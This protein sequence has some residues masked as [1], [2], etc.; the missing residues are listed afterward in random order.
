MWIGV[1]IAAGLAVLAALAPEGA[2]AATSD[3]ARSDQAAVR[4]V[5]ASDAVGGEKAIR[6]GF[7]VELAPGWKIYWRS[8]G[9]AGLPPEFDWSGS[10]NLGT[11]ETAWPVPHRFTLFG[12]DTF[13]Y[14]TEVVLPLTATVARSGE[15]VF[16]RTHVRYLVCDP[17][18]CVPQEA[19][20]ALALPGGP[21]APSAEA[22]LIQRF[23]VRVP[24]D[25]TDVGLFLEGVRLEEAAG[26]HILVASIRGDPPLTTPDLIV[27]G[28]AAYRF[29]APSVTLSEGGRRGV[30]RVEAVPVEPNPPAL[31]ATTLTLT[32]IDGSRGLERRVVPSATPVAPSASALAGILGL[33]LLGGFI[34]NFMPCVL[35]VLSIK[36]LGVIRQGGQGRSRV[37]ASFL[38]TAAGVVFSFLA[39]AASLALLKSAGAAIGWGIQFQQPLFLTALAL[40]L[41]LFAGNLFGF[42]EVPLPGWAGGLAG[43][44]GAGAEGHGLLGPFAAG[45]FATLLATP[46]S[47]PFLGTAVG[48]ALA[49]GGAE[50]FAIFLA[51][52]LGLAAPYLLVAA[53]PGLVRWLP[54][55]GR[56]MRHLRTGLGIAL[57]VTAAWLVSILTRQASPTAAALAATLLAAVLA[58][59][60]VRPRLPDRLRL[61]VPPAVAVAALLVLVLP[62]RV[63]DAPAAPAPSAMPG[64]AAAG[65]WRSFDEAEIPALVA[66]GKTVLVD[67]TADW[68]LTCQV[69]KKLVLDA[70]AVRAVLDRPETVAL[71]A[72]WTRPDDRIARYLASFGRYGI[73]FNAVYGP[74]APRGILLPEVL[75]ESRVLEALARARGG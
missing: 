67:V 57:L 35:P 55:P 43:R 1:G 45:A 36:L 25:G 40:V 19:D 13:G 65:L 34:L 39:L 11:V 30:L 48:F 14:E 73:P 28:P 60:A 66:A 70:S 44:T 62:G 41:V 6:L 4:L 52:G 49:R 8:P 71:R 32:L 2:A 20:L 68:C 64:A 59:L 27:E 51:L 17:R 33:A 75:T 18:I 74:G 38:A 31:A 10:D 46:C 7:H 47:A 16:L 15:P 37:R 29:A 72:D 56:W 24:Q 42:F 23:A 61:A 5:S 22:G 9:D 21:A 63:A 26:R 53:A 12:L 3:W 58:L 50:I 54:R 69:N